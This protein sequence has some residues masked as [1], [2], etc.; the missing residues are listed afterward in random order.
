MAVVRCGAD[1]KYKYAAIVPHNEVLLAVQLAVDEDRNRT[2][3]E[4]DKLAMF[5]AQLGKVWDLLPIS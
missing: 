4:L 1:D 5:M 2:T 3:K